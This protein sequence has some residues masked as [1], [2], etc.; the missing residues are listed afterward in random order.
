[1]WTL[2][3]TRWLQFWA[4]LEVFSRNHMTKVIG[5]GQVTVGAIAA[6]AGDLF[7]ARTMKLILMS[8]GLLTAWRGFVNSRNRD[9]NES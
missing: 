4:A 6:N 7:S 2:V 3:W 1:M 9:D 8:S 5:F